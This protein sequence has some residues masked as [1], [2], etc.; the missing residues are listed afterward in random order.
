M[1]ECDELDA[2]Q[3]S[4]YFDHGA[5]VAEPLTLHIRQI[6][7]DGSKAFHPKFIT[8]LDRATAGEQHTTWDYQFNH[9]WII[10]DN[11]TSELIGAGFERETV[12]AVLMVRRD[13]K[14][15]L[16]AAEG[17]GLTKATLRMF[18]DQME[19]YCRDLLPITK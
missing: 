2:G 16:D 5:L 17:V 7:P 4:G 15:W 18:H 1:A 14:D 9:W 12:E 13:G 6:A 19:R 3:E 11:V 10:P 8:W